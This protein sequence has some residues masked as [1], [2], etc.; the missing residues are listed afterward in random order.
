MQLSDKSLVDAIDDFLVAR[1][2]AKP[3][4][5]TTSAYRADLIGIGQ[6]LASGEGDDA[7]KAVR[8]SHLTTPHLR[9]AFATFADDHAKASVRRAWSAWNT[10]FAYLVAEGLAE[11]NPMQAIARPKRTATPV[12]VIRGS[13]ITER[14]LEAAGNRDPDAPAMWPERDVALIAAFAV[15]GLRLAEVLSLQ[16]GSFD[17]PTGA[18]RLTVVGKGDKARTIPVWP[19]LE[20]LID[21]YMRA[22]ADR[23][24]KHDVESP[25]TV[26]F[27]DTNGA[28]LRRHQVQ[29]LIDRIYRRAGIRAQ[30]PQGALVHALRHTFATT[31]LEGGASVLEVSQLLG[32]ASL[33]TTRRYLEA[34]ADELRDA[35]KA[36]PAQ[37]AIHD[38]VDRDRSGA[39]AAP[40]DETAGA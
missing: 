19:D 29:Y 15:T 28:P 3:S 23:F 24:P 31:A 6:R 13:G 14:M 38:Y 33:D 1:S 36:H 37:V 27:V 10:F 21:R 17:G 32:H 34:T 35:I 26:V 20:T 5:H 22:R 2:T 40:S 25:A 4:R 39:E 9:T 7:V 18:R 12:K 30:V 16:M 8:V 11:G